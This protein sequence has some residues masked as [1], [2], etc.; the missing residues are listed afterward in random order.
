[1]D[2]KN[3]QF[4]K[5]EIKIL[6]YIFK[7]FRDRY[8]AR[9]LARELSLNHA[10]ANKLCHSL[11]EKD[12]IKREDIGNSIYY[13]FDYDNELALNFVRYLLSLE[14][15]EFPRWLNV[16]ARCLAK[17]N[18]HVLFGCIFGSSIKSSTFNDID[19]LLVYDPK[20]KSKV[21]TVKDSIRKSE[22]VEKPIRYVEIT[23]KDIEKN[24]DDKTFYSILSDCLIFY[25][26]AKYIEMAKCLRN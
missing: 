17:F 24:K 13:T 3:I 4:T 1:M 21:K 20:N 15:K 26:P 9:Q 12:L 6:K 25:N 2:V 19:V 11:A 7:H 14:V 23:E 8:N 16:L 10:H 18:E 5:I 22:L